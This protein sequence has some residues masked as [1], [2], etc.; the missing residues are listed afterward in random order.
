MEVEDVLKSIANALSYRKTDRLV[1]AA[2][3]STWDVLNYLLSHSINGTYAILFL[4][5]QMVQITPYGIDVSITLSKRTTNNY[6]TIHPQLNEK[7]LKF[8][9][10]VFTGLELILYVMCYIMFEKQRHDYEWETEKTRVRFAK[11]ASLLKVKDQNDYD[12][13]F[14]DIFFVRDAFAHSFIAVDKIKYRGVPLSKSFGVT[15]TW[16]VHTN[17]EHIFIDGLDELFA[18]IMSLFCEHQMK[19]IDGN[20]FA[21]MCNK[22]LGSRGLGPDR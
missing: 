1:E 13:L 22:L 10:R 20:K 14:D 12:K 16:A 3:D 6:L 9:R 15:Y 18:P 8:L 19:Q 11:F 21:R 4:T 7:F 5:G 17:A 2:K